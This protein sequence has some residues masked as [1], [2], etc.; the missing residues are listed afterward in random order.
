MRR[1]V[2]IVTRLAGSV[3]PIVSISPWRHA[4]AQSGT[5]PTGVEFLQGQVT[6]FQTQFQQQ[7]T[8]WSE[9]A[10]QLQ[11]H[12]KQLQ[13]QNAVQQAELQA[14][15]KEFNKLAKLELELQNANANVL[16]LEGNLHVRGTMLLCFTRGL[17]VLILDSVKHHP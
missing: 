13:A 12:A 8:Q 9:H 10:K 2:T 15:N 17:R 4:R 11:E 16:L 6:W 7:Q 3:N 14:L 1:A 5:T